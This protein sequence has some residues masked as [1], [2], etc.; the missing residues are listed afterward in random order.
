MEKADAFKAISLFSGAQGLDVGLGLA[1]INIVLGQD[2]EPSCIATMTANG[3]RGVL[4]DIR[5]MQAETL[6]AETG[7][8]PGEPFLVCG[9]PP[10]QPFSTAGK[11]LGVNDPKGGGGACSEILPAW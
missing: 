5:T 4:G 6:L 7:M 3:H 9:G 11:R 8:V 2:V 10:C 1:G